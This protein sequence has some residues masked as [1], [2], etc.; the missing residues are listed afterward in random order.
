MLPIRGVYEV[1]VP[2][3]DL[4]RAESF[5]CDV[6]GLRVGQR[7]HERRWLFLWVA[8]NAGMVVLQ[9]TEGAFERTHFAFAVDAPELDRATAMLVDQGFKV[10]GPITIEWMPARSTYFSD[11]D[12]H[13]LEV[14]AVAE[15]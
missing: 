3:H 8:G 6:L 13:Q 12:G 1:V 7:D 2:V 14:C 4:S 11:P 15:K 5:Y 10:E 9:E